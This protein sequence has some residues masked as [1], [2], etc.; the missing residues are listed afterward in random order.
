[1]MKRNRI[2]LDIDKKLGRA[3][4]DFMKKKEIK[5]YLLLM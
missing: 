2:N 3:R 1:M 5:I 4:I